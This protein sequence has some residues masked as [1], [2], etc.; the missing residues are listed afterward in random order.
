[1]TAAEQS[2]SEEEARDRKALKALVDRVTSFFL[3][4]SP[5]EE[6]PEKLSQ[7]SKYSSVPYGSIAMAFC[8]N[9][10]GLLTTVSIPYRLAHSAA[11][12][13]HYQRIHMA[14]RIRSLKSRPGSQPPADQLEAI[15]DREARAHANEN[16]DKFV[17]SAEGR[18]ALVRDSLLFLARVYEDS[19]LADAAQELILQGVVLCWGA[20]EVLARDCFVAHLNANPQRVKLLLDH[21]VAKRRFEVSKVSVETL[22]AHQFDLSG[23][24]GSL[25]AQ[26]QDLSDIQSIKSVYEALFLANGGLLR[27]VDD[28]SLRILSLRRNLIVH[29][30]GVIDDVYAGAASCTQ[31]VGE[32][33]KV[34]PDDLEQHL[35]SV[36]VVAAGILDAVGN[37]DG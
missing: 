34:S 19:S 23:R 9:V 30:R 29:N 11:V 18:D 24:M 32:R 20:F 31:K 22:A 14:A 10:Q 4:P 21:P 6:M 8:A 36:I 25:L 27:L 13:Q 1:M 12:N 17:E 5:P 15:R 26:Q 35:N 7:I 3:V 37:C 16:M 28:K 2:S 33:L